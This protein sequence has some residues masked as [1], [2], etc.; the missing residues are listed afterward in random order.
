MEDGIA[1][2]SNPLITFN[3]NG[4]GSTS[5]YW[6]FA[7][8]EYDTEEEAYI[9]KRMVAEN[10]W[11]TLFD[12]NIFAPNGEYVFPCHFP[13]PKKEGMCLL[14]LHPSDTYYN[15]TVSG[16]ISQDTVEIHF[17]SI[18]EAH[19]ITGDCTINIETK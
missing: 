12:I 14:F 9:A 2:A 18:G 8:G 17:G 16:N 15:T 19:I 5:T 4:F 11:D 7:I 10:Y 1:N 3:F 13:I 6:Y